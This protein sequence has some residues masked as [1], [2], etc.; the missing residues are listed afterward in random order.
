M[1]S[2]FLITLLCRASLT[3]ALTTDNGEW[4]EPA[5]TQLEIGHHPFIRFKTSEEF[6]ATT[7]SM[8]CEGTYQSDGQHYQFRPVTAFQSNHADIN[9]LAEALDPEA[10]RKMQEGY[11]RALEPFDADYDASTG[12]LRMHYKVNG[13]M[14]TFSLLSY[15]AGDDQLPWTVAEDARSMVGLWKMIE[16]FPER[17]DSKTRFRIGGLEG[18]QQFF[19][20]A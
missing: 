9:K 18:L 16:P 12:Y 6:I 5:M 3:S 2:S 7:P 14:Q 20:E 19:E 10:G 1:V 8:I 13:E 4:E 11:S 15:T 17:L